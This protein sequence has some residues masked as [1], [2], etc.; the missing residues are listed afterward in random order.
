[1][2]VKNGNKNEILDIDLLYSTFIPDTLIKHEYW[3]H[4]WNL[5]VILP[6]AIMFVFPML[7]LWYV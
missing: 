3:V 6:L 2:D 4:V 5:L 7:I 1:M